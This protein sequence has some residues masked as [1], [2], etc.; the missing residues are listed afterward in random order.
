MRFAELPDAIKLWQ[1]L[2]GMLLL[3]GYVAMMVSIFGVINGTAI[4]TGLLLISIFM[5]RNAVA[6]GLHDLDALLM[7]MPLIGALYER[8]IRKKTY[9]RFDTRIMYYESIKGI[10]NEKME[11]V[12]LAKGITL[13]SVKQRYPSIDDLYRMTLI[14]PESPNS[15]T[16]E[17]RQ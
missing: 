14:H 10:V 13:N 16:D 6:M 3:C 15:L 9:Y 8:I 12:T 2:L 1:L 5:A 11:Q 4:L 7:K 17:P